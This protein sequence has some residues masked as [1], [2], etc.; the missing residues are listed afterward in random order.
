MLL[1]LELVAIEVE[2]ALLALVVTVAATVVLEVVCIYCLWV[3]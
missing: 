2:A 1:A 3:R